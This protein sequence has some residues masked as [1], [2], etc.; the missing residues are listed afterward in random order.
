M[1]F[2]RTVEIKQSPRSVW[3]TLMD[4]D[5]WDKWATPLGAPRRVSTGAWDLGWRGRLG[6]TVY[7]ITE[8]ID[9]TTGKRM[10]WTGSGLG[11]TTVWTVLVEPMRGKT[12]ATFIVETSG[13]MP[14]LLGR[15]TGKG[16]EKKLK[17]TL[18]GFRREAEASRVI[19][20]VTQG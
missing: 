1:R 13:W 12:E 17:D 18:E 3:A 16:F 5:R 6:N 2:S 14:A 20:K 9:E 4:F 8:L 15:W 7:E 10:I 19:P 11:Q